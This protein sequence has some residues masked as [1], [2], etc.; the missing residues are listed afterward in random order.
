MKIAHKTTKPRIVPA[1]TLGPGDVFQCSKGGL[2]GVY[3]VVTAADGQRAL[4]CLDGNFPV[5][6]F[7]EDLEVEL[8]AADLMLRPV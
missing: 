8:Y 1:H 4:V 3:L 7:R 2:D 5:L 6:E